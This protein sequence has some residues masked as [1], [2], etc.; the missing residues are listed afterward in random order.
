MASVDETDSKNVLYLRLKARGRHYHEKVPVLNRLPF[1][2]IAI[3]GLLLVVNI[4]VWI[5][6]GIALVSIPNFYL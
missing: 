4:L 2:S 6:V 3:I 1:P 5:A